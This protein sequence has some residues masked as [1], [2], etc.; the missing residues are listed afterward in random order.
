MHH[1]FKAHSA[2]LELNPQEKL[3]HIH[4]HGEVDKKYTLL[5]SPSCF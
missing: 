2:C 4:M 1:L 5:N 3:V